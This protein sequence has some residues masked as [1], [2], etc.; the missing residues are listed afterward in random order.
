M[1]PS[2]HALGYNISPLPGLG[3]LRHFLNVNPSVVNLDAQ[4]GAEYRVE[5]SLLLPWSQK[6]G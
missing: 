1:F 4:S 2:A 6:G 3:S 5:M